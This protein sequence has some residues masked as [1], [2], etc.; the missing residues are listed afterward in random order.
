MKNVEEFLRLAR[1]LSN[2][3]FCTR[4][5]FGAILVKHNRIIGAS[6]NFPI[7]TKKVCGINVQCL[8]DMYSEAS[9]LSYTHCPAIHAEVGAILDAAVSGK[10]TKNATLFL[11]E[12]NGK[13][14]RPCLQC[15]RIAVVAQL[16]DC[17]FYDKDGKVCHETIDDW[18]KLEEEWVE[19]ELKGERK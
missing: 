18:I 9:Y 11:A 3:S 10:S 8:K 6:C 2:M 1:N 7:N 13:C 17:F 5:K 4:R 14:E 15:R 12:A 16:K 19:N